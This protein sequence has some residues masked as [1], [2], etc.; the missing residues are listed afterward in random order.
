MTEREKL[1][2]E[3]PRRLKRMVE[4]DSRF[5]YEVV[6]AALWR[7]FGGRDNAAIQRRYQFQK[8]RVENLKEARDGYEEEL[9]EE[10][11]LLEEIKAEME[12]EN[13]RLQRVLDDA[14]EALKPEQLT[15]DN[16]AVQRFAQEADIPPERL[17]E[18]LQDRMDVDLYS[19]GDED[20]EQ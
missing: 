18:R 12:A 9:Q 1:G 19:G 16:L 10:Q 14:E 15:P 3:I 11:E 7:E 20:V 4:R 13:E 2:V 5:N 17:I 6:E 8:Q